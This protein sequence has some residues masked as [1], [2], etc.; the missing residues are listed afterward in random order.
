MMK[1]CLF[2]EGKHIL[3]MSAYCCFNISAV[4]DNEQASNATVCFYD[5]TAI[6]PLCF[7]DIF[8]SVEGSEHP[9]RKKAKK[10]SLTLQETNYVHIYSIYTFSS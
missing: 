1:K 5:S 3:T 9:S 6:K 10:K 4:A 2:S 8:I 7:A